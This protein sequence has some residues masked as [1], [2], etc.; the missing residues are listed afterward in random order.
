[1]AQIS[2]WRRGEFSGRGIRVY[3]AAISVVFWGLIGTCWLIFPDEHNF[4]ILTH[5]F[6]YLGSFDAD[7]NPEGWWLFTLA[8]CFWAITA[9]PM[10][11]YLARCL[12]GGAPVLARRGR[13]WLLLG[14]AGIG[15]VGLFPDAGI[16]FHGEFGLSDLHNLGAVAVALGFIIGASHFAAIVFRRSAP[17]RLHRARWPHGV[18]LT[19]TV[20]ALYFL[21]R[22]EFIYYRLKTEADAA[23][24]T[25]GSSW[26]EAMNTIYAFPL[27][28]NVFVLVAFVYLVWSAL[29]LSTAS[30]ED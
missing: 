17:A 22:W 12:E 21:I 20:V 26:Q 3:V 5:T 28:D 18:F 16:T 7:R 23:G 27:W 8:M 14:C 2:D 15:I 13:R 19:V 4:W 30:G 1:M 6:S 9:V 11:R 24:V 29:A 25:V 10:V